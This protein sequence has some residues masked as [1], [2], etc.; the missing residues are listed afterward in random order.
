M[1]GGG[2]GHECGGC[3]KPSAAPAPAPAPTACAKCRQAELLPGEALCPACLFSAVRSKYRQALR[4][5]NM[6]EAGDAVALAFSGGPA[7]AA[8]LHLVLATRTER[9]DRP[10]RG[11][12]LLAAAGGG[13]AAAAAL[14]CRY[15]RGGAAPPRRGVGWVLGA[16]R[17][18][19]CELDG[20][21]RPPCR[22]PSR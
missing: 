2:C 1:T 4:A 9:V 21:G 11:K 16:A 19:S 18:A 8:L 12:V 10:D 15:T 22:W 17:C 3:S 6:L 13:L 7:S 5:G 14:V 20:P